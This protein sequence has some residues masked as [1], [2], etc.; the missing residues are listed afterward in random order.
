L[1]LAKSA[2]IAS[3]ID[4][5]SITYHLSSPEDFFEHL[6][7]ITNSQPDAIALARLMPIKAVE[8]FDDFAPEQ[9][10]DEVNARR[11]L[12]VSGAVE[13][14]RAFFCPVKSTF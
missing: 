13:A 5:I 1:L 7:E 12:D 6:R 10:L 9:L 3:D 14:C 11:R 8:K 4:Q 2:K